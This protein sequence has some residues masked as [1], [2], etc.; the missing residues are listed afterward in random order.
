MFSASPREGPEPVRPRSPRYKRTVKARLLGRDGPWIWLYKPAG[1]PVFPW[2]ADPAAPCLL[3]W[4]R[5]QGAPTGPF[6]EGFEAGI[7]HRLDN[8]TSGVVM[9]AATPA[10]LEQIRAAFGAGSLRKRYRFLSHRQVPWNEHHLSHALAHHPKK[11]ALMVFQRGKNT[12]HR[13]RWYPADTRLTRVDAHTWEAVITTG[14]THQ[15]RL[16]AASAGLAL[17]GDRAYGGGALGQ[18][19]PEGVEFPLHHLGMEGTTPEGRPVR[20]PTVEVPDWWSIIRRTFPDL[21]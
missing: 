18:G 10:D 19:A 9:A 1:L 13:G 15:V 2:H 6:P 8:S 14:V 11:K 3:S 16:H 17:A 7:A 12:P 5:A 20:S 21:G 4:Y